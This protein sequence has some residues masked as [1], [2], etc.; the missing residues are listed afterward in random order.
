MQELKV[1]TEEGKSIC[2]FNRYNI[3]SSNIYAGAHRGVF[4][5]QQRKKTASRGD[6]ESLMMPAASESPRYFS[7]VFHSGPEWLERWLDVRGAQRI[8]SMM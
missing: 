5:F 3:E 4:F 2:I 6:K 8:K 1:L 7:I